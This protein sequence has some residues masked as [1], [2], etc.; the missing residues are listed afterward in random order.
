MTLDRQMIQKKVKEVLAEKCCKD[1]SAIHME[2]SL[3]TDLGMDSLDAVETVFEFEE[4]Y[5][6]EIPD[7]EVQAFRKVRDIVAYL[8]TRLRGMEKS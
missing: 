3:V 5:G 8:E 2:S 4:S 1:P 7:E 6:L